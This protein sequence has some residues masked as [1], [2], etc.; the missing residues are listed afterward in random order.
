MA[1]LNEGDIYGKTSE[2]FEASKT[3]NAALLG[4][5]LQR[6]NSSERTTAIEMRNTVY[7]PPQLLQRLDRHYFDPDECPEYLFGSDIT[8]LIISIYKGNFDCVKVLLKYKADIE[9]RGKDS[10]FGTFTPMFAAA[11]YG[12]L[13][14]LRCLVENG[15]DVNARTDNNWTP[16]MAASFEGHANAI[17]YLVEHGANMDLQDD[18]GNTALHHA[19]EFCIFMYNVDECDPPVDPAV[20]DKPDDLTKVA[21]ILL[22][23]GAS[24]LYNN[25][26]LTPLLKASKACSVP[27]VEEL[28]KRPEFNQ[29][30]RIDALEL[31]G[32][33]I[34]LTHLDLD[35]SNRSRT[36]RSFEYIERGMQERFKDLLHPLLKKAMDPIEAYQNRKESQT[37]EE[38]ARIENDFDAIIMESLIIY[39]RILGTDSLELHDSICSVAHYYEDD[40][41]VNLDICVGL[42]KHGMEIAQCCNES[43][44]YDLNHLRYIFHRMVQN[45]IPPKQKVVIEVIEDTIQGYTKQQENL[46][47]QLEDEPDEQ[48]KLKLEEKKKQILSGVLDELLVL[49]QSFVKGE[50]CEE[51]NET[52]DPVLLSNLSR[53]D[54]RDVWQG[55]TLLHIAVDRDPTYQCL[56]A[57]TTTL[58]LNAGVNVNATNNN[59]D[60]PLHRAVTFKPANSDMLHHLTETLK[61]LL[62]RGAHLDFVNNNGKTAMDLAEIDEACWMLFEKKTLEL[63]CIAA[64][65]VKEFGLPYLGLVPKTLEKFISM[66]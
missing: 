3:G 43:I 33:S 7:R 59:G 53:L 9:G 19:I 4:E 15:G 16:L 17:T 62:D 42:R 56:C 2:V 14:V 21:R 24:Q 23:L 63:K 18:D 8:P 31:L 1:C 29:E 57:K 28:I 44:I 10:G 35:E 64:R 55:N 41:H 65:A 30:Q 5:L 46:Q 54:L 39:E 48:L 13:H 37:P 26:R 50:L 36:S 11:R 49:L 61:V 6:M 47:R 52:S 34:A 20:G 38:V 12:R 58:L 66:H 22:T 27:L 45:K 40:K 32:A 25:R 51:D 60:T